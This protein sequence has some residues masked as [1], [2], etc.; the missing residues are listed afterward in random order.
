VHFE[1][2]MKNK[3]YEKDTI[4]E[5]H[6]RAPAPDGAPRTSANFRHGQPNTGS[7]G[8]QDDVLRPEHPMADA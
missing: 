8:R 1:I 5:I 6:S 2:F 7:D 4:L 3:I